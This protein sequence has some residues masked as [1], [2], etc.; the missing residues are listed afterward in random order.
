MEDLAQLELDGTVARLTLNRPEARNALSIELLEALHGRAD[1]LARAHDATVCVLTGAGKSFCAG[2]DLKKV[3]EEPGAPERLLA[4]LAEL[5]LKLRN[6]PQ[7]LVGRINGAAIGGG[8]GLA[9]LCDLSIT[10]A[11]AKLGYPEVDIG[12][13]PAVVAPWLIRRVGSGMARRILLR[14]GTMSGAE[15]FE[16]GMVTS[17]VESVDV[18]DEAVGELV[19]RLA[20]A[21]PNA[22]RA[23]KEWMNTMDGEMLAEQVREGARIS[24]SMVETP[25]ARESLARLFA[26]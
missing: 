23:T 1:E 20:G 24:A 14:G 13:C 6:I 8:C 3:L 2:M 26:R 12:V 11:D 9:C 18:L 7:V 4:S 22:L 25:E 15:A 17:C 10:H 19:D 16:L 5:T 21:E